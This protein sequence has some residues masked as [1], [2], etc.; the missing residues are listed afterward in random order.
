M[1]TNYSGYSE[2]HVSYGYIEPVTEV[3]TEEEV[4]EETKS[5]E[6]KM[7]RVIGGDL[8]LRK[9]ASSDSDPVTILKDNEE[10]MITEDNDPNWV[11]VYTATGQEGFCKREFIKFE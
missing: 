11:G 1:K 10:L 5:D 3:L 6:M 7:G 8:Y 2:K 4:I 9:E